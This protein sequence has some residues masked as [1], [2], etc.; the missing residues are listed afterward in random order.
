MASNLMKDRICKCVRE[1]IKIALTD[2][3]FLQLLSV[4]LQCLQVRGRKYPVF[5]LSGY[6]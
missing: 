2:L 1:R 3:Q 6:S 4:L 5:M